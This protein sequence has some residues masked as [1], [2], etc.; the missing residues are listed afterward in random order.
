M[1]E[2]LLYLTASRPNIIFS[3]CMCAR[4]QSD[5]RESHLPTSRRIFRYLSGTQNVGLWY[6]NN[7]SFEL[8]AYSDS[9]FAG[10]KLD[11][12]STSREC[13]FLEKNL[14]SWS[15]RKQNSIALS[16]TKAEHVVAGSCCTQII[17]IKYQLADYGIELNKVPIRC[18]NKS[19]INL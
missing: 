11:K 15:S 14:I 7:F 17:W 3:I 1:I 8:I 4:Y 5:P 10:Y 9:N 13:H 12:K 2:S 19:V 18:D 6:S 16:F